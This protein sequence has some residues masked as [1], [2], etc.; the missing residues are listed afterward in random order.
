MV[1]LILLVRSPGFSG[2]VHLARLVILSIVGITGFSGP[3][4]VDVGP[5]ELQQRTIRCGKEKEESSR[6]RSSSSSSRAVFSTIHE[7]IFATQRGGCLKAYEA[8]MDLV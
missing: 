6:Y 8:I 7:E 2:L 1:I 3:F 5:G 4:I